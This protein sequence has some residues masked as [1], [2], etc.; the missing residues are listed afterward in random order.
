MERLEHGGIPVFWERGTGEAM[1]AILFRGGIADELPH[2]RGE[3]HLVEHLALFALG[4]RAYDYNGFVDPLFTV[5]H[6]R[7][8]QAEVTGFLTDICRS[9]GDLPLE[10]FET[11]VE[12]LRTEAGADAGHFAARVLAYRLGVTGFG[13]DHL[14]ELGLKTLGPGDVAARRDAAFTAGNAAVW[15]FS[16][17]PPQ[18][19]LEL[20]DGPS[21][22]PPPAEPVPGYEFPAWIA[23]GT[24]GAGVSMFGTRSS[25]LSLGIGVLAERLHQ[26]LRLDEGLAYAVEAGR[27]VLSADLTHILVSADCQDRNAPAV[28]L[29]GGPRF[30]DVEQGRVLAARS[31]R[32]PARRSP[33]RPPR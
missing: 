16:P 12:I 28:A 33:C 24:L 7:G 14:T 21:R 15:M 25:A 26:R 22:P 27:Y 9:L 11:E 2:R 10:R 30:Q 17:E 18:L 13:V 20:P 31:P 23:S 4:R 8:S 5:F 3:T 29:G 32:R 1:A 6:A 19:E